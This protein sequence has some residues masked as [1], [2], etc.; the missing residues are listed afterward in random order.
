M[1]RL[2]DII[3]SENMSI[4]SRS[5]PDGNILQLSMVPL[6]EYQMY[7]SQ[8]STDSIVSNEMR[9]GQAFIWIAKDTATQISI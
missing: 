8:R 6:S 1:K 5:D 2:F 7:G 3:T 4:V 9:C